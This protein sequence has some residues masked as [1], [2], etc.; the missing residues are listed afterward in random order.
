MLILKTLWKRKGKEGLRV[1]QMTKW[2]IGIIRYK[3][4]LQS[5]EDWVTKYGD[6]EIAWKNKI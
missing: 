6:R 4:P 2:V 1:L 5:Y 3:D